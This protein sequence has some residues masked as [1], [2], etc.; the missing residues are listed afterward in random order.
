ML[1]Q[2]YSDTG[3]Y[4]L[5][6]GMPG[7][8][9]RQANLRA[10]Y[11]RARQYEATTLRGLF[12]FLRFVERIKERGGDL[13]AA[14]ALGE[15]E[16]VVR[17]ITVH[18]SKGLEFPIV[19]VAGLAK[20]FNMQDLRQD[21]LLH[22]ELGFGPKFMDTELRLLYPTLPWLALRSQ[23]LRE[24]LAEEMRILY[25]ALTRA[26]E[27]LI[28]VAAVNDLAKEVQK[29]AAISRS[30]ERLLPAYYRSRA[31]CCLDWIGP[32]LLR[33]AQAGALREL[34]KEA[35]SGAC[36]EEEEPSS[37][38]VRLFTPRDVAGSG[39]VPDQ[40]RE[41]GR[42]WQEEVARL[43]PVPVRSPWAGEVARRLDWRYPYGEAESR[44]AKMSV[45]ELRK[46]LAAGLAGEDAGE[47]PWFKTFPL[48]GLRPRFL[49]ESGLTAAEKGTAY[50]TVMQHL[51]LQPLP[52]VDSIK[53]QVEAMTTRELLTEPEKE[54]V[55][56]EAVAAFF[57]TPLGRKIAC[58]ARVQREVPFSMALPASEVYAGEQE[59]E[60][61][62]GT[63]L[64]GEYVLI[65]GV[66][67]CLVWDEDGLLLVDYKTD[68][69]SGVDTETLRERYRQQLELY[70]RAVETIWKV[71][72]KGR[73]LYFF[74]S[75]QVV[76]V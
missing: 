7:G 41:R 24:A 11:D 56:P 32:A 27:K 49:G 73:Y 9:Q 22:R 31:K 17:I 1:W 6:G 74:D 55:D 43:A 29:W 70:S 5:V 36:Q 76:N 68:K 25:V 58:A 61:N 16:D 28:L 69:T 19:F 34:Q 53:R 50:H 63:S 23:L 60:E 2:I 51:I 35:L 45:T 42:R 59:G 14:R 62:R 65:Q 40:E 37:W 44:L 52:D 66:I 18:K 46:L 54:A 10:L 21:F 57:R 39:A 67:D 4:D 64:Q 38:S 71:K 30:G 20:Q 33:H 12:R 48:L 3:Y 26:Q 75:R 47:A 15:Q 13:D 8:A 72:V